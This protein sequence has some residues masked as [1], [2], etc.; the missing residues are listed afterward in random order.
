MEEHEHISQETNHNNEI[1]SEDNYNERLETPY[2]GMVFE[3]WEEAQKY[4]GDYGRQ[5]GFWIRIRSSSKARA[6]LDEAHACS[7]QK[8][9]RSTFFAGM[10]TTGRSE[11]TNSKFDHLVTPTTNLKE[12]MI[13]F[14]DSLKRIKKRE[15]DEDYDTEHKFRIVKDDEFLLK[16]AAKVYTR[17]VYN[18]FKYELSQVNKYKVEEHEAQ[19][20]YNIYMV[21]RK[22]GEPEELVVKLNLQT[23][24]ESAKLAC[25][26]SFSHKDC[27]IYTEA[28]KDLSKK[29]NKDK[30]PLSAISEKANGH[31]DGTSHPDDTNAPSILL[32]DPNISQT[33]G[34]KKDVNTSGRLKSSIELSSER[35]KRKY[36][37]LS[38]LAIEMLS[39]MRKFHMKNDHE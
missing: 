2:V 19:D 3:T 4:Y 20:S 9:N 17:N 39:K 26:A 21:K 32:L 37:G 33:K 30:V 27:L 38:H 24:E 1:H 7:C 31:P 29:L 28:M 34:R 36:N 16:H 10:N 23:Y 18:K 11:S 14:D 15:S 12:F 5:E 35:K 13:K 6:S 25:I 8:S 22:F